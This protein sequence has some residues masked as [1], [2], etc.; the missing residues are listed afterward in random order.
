MVDRCLCVNTQSQR[1]EHPEVLYELT[2]Y[3]K[4]SN[5][6]AESNRK[7]NITLPSMV[8]IE[9]H[10]RISD[11]SSTSSLLESAFPSRLIYSLLES[12]LHTVLLFPSHPEPLKRK[13]ISRSPDC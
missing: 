8:F 5:L 9:P 6:H 13:P 3:T 12:L 2:H 4:E 11:P 10:I 7:S 1:K